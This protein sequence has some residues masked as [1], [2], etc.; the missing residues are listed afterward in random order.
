MHRRSP[1]FSIAS[2][3]SSFRY[4]FRGLWLVVTTQPNARLH[5]AAA[6]AVSLLGLAVQLSRLEW[7]AVLLAIGLVWMAEAL[8]TALEQLGNAITTQSHPY[9]RNAKDIA[10]AAVLI[11]AA[12]ACL[13]G[14][15]VFTPHLL[16]L[17]IRWGGGL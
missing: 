2:R 16:T 14:S 8:N 9:I 5:A 11:A 13:V 6:A 10:A 1:R 17:F 15:V 12:I 4:A 3:L 7:C